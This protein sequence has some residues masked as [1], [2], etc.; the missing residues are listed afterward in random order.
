MAIGNVIEQDKSLGCLYIN[1]NGN[2]VV[3]HARLA[4]SYVYGTKESAYAQ[5]ESMKR[6]RDRRALERIKAKT[7]NREHYGEW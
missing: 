7:P 2:F 1:G 6:I 3:Y 5:W 4:R